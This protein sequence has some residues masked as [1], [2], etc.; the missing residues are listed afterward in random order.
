MT[1]TTCGMSRSSKF[2]T[3][4]LI[5]TQCEICYVKFG[6]ILTMHQ[7]PTERSKKSGST[8]HGYLD[9]FPRRRDSFWKTVTAVEQVRVKVATIENDLHYLKTMM[10]ALQSQLNSLQDHVRSSQPW[11]PS[12]EGS[13]QTP[14]A[15]LLLS[16][17]EFLPEPGRS[18]Y[19]WQ[20]RR[21]F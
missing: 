2:W 18:E 5:N 19:R 4:R 7:I 14:E 1:F 8:L 10:A 17:D 9:G 16:L 20:G 21:A 12:S 13:A 3:A 15:R 6:A 11:L